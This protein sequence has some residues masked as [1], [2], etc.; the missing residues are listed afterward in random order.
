M[1]WYI[2]F[3]II[4]LRSTWTKTSELEDLKEQKRTRKSHGQG[5]EPE[6]KTKETPVQEVS[7][8]AKKRGDE[9]C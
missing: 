5:K 8:M 4:L 1:R 2:I 7:R 6:E 3:K 9:K